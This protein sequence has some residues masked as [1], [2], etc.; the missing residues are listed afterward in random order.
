MKQISAKTFGQ[1]QDLLLGTQRQVSE[2]IG[3]EVSVQLIHPRQALPV[4][5]TPERGLTPELIL[6]SCAMACDEDVSIFCAHRSTE[7]IS[8]IKQ[9]ARYMLRQYTDLS[10]KRI[11]SLTGCTN[12]TT[13]MHSVKK[14]DDMIAVNDS[15]FMSFYE[16]ITAYIQAV[17]IELDNEKTIAI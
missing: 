5:M 6:R 13:S 3:I 14:V 10:H 17:K 8:C 2:M 12:H 1:V 16:R 4:I 11:A 9:I 7:R 15:Y